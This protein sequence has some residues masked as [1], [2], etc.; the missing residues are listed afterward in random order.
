MG[1]L[2]GRAVQLDIGRDDVAV[3]VEGELVEAGPGLLLDDHQAMIDVAAGAAKRGADLGAEQPRFAGSVPHF[4]RGLERLL[5][6]LA[7]RQALAR[8]EAA[9]ALAKD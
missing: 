4:A 1:A 2:L 6:R 5:P 8:K 7:V 3:Q 9:D